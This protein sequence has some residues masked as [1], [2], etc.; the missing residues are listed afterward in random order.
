MKFIGV[1]SGLRCFIDTEAGRAGCA[2]AHQ[3]TIQAAR[4][5]T[6]RLSDD[7]V[8]NLASIQHHSAK[9]RYRKSKKLRGD[10]PFRPQN[11]NT[12]RFVFIKVSIP[13][14]W[15]GQPIGRQRQLNR[16]LAAASVHGVHTE[17]IIKFV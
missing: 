10:Q 2:A 5:T 9:T 14:F 3:G 7:L 16:Y 8:V 11:C 15:S 13:T 4:T 12:V 17:L 6:T 1:I